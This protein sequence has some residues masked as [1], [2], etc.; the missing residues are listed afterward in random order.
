MRLTKRPASGLNQTANQTDAFSV[1]SSQKLLN[2]YLR[3][4]PF[5]QT[6]G[7]GYSP[8]EERGNGVVGRH[9]VAKWQPLIGLRFQLLQHANKGRIQRSE[10]QE[11][12]QLGVASMAKYGCVQAAPLTRKQTFV[13]FRNGE[14]RCCGLA[15][16]KT[17]VHFLN[18]RL[19]AESE[20]SSQCDASSVFSRRQ[21]ESLFLGPRPE[22]LL[23]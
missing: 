5:G 20:S 3:R 9:E 12:W 18:T 1:K 23:D 4:R 11:G 21:G 22:P 15:H 2:A 7:F 14:W 17:A 10:A 13:K 19:G 16:S 6:P 8:P